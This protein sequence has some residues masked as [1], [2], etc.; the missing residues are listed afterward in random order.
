M[1]DLRD[2]AQQFGLGMWLADYPYDMLYEQILD[3]LHSGE[4][5][6]AE[7]I[8]LW[9]PVEDLDGRTVAE[10]IDD[11]RSSFEQRVAKIIANLPAKEG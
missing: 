8:V 10:M 1:I 3:Q 5:E 2:E 11:T 4:Y 6:E 7:D 9:E